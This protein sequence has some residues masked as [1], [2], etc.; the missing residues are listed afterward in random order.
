MRRT[1]R[2]SAV[3]ALRSGSELDFLVAE[4]IFE[5]ARGEQ[6]TQQKQL[7]AKQKTGV[8]SIQ[9]GI[10]GDISSTRKRK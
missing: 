7:P 1:F 2:V 9:A 10:T 4:E 8:G 3:A 6:S 5:G